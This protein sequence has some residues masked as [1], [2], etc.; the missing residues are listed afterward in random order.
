MININKKKY[1]TFVTIFLFSLIFYAS[2]DILSFIYFDYLYEVNYDAHFLGHKLFNRIVLKTD[3]EIYYVQKF[4]S[5]I[6]KL[7]FIFISFFAYYFFIYKQKLLVNKHSKFI[8]TFFIGVVFLN[9]FDIIIFKNYDSFSN[10]IYVLILVVFYFSINQTLLNS[11]IFTILKNSLIKS[12]Y[13]YFYFFLIL[14]VIIILIYFLKSQG[15]T[16]NLIENGN[17]TLIISDLFYSLER[18]TNNFFSV[19]I[20]P[21][22]LLIFVLFFFIISEVDKKK[23]FAKIFFVALFIFFILKS[24]LFI[25]FS[26]II[27]I[28]KFYERKI[29]INYIINILFF[30]FLFS[31]LFFFPLFFNYIFNFFGYEDFLKS[32]NYYTELLF[33]IDCVS[34]GLNCNF[35]IQ[36]LINFFDI[37][38]LYSIY[39][40]FI[41]RIT[42]NYEFLNYF[43]DNPFVFLTNIDNFNDY[44]TDLNVGKKKNS[45]M[46]TTHNSFNYLTLK[47]SIFVTLIFIFSLYILSLKL[48]KNKCYL[49]LLFL[50]M[51]IGIMLYDDHL[52]MNNLVGSISMWVSLGLININSYEKKFQ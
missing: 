15:V 10:L 2:T 18:F 17:Y 14:T 3:Q 20:N 43:Y 28:F 37:S 48:L 51:L 49:N 40:S 22:S 31:F 6:H 26:T 29:K 39:I 42:M 47:Y 25:I 16:S 46:I 45:I 4:I 9:I 7:L 23:D 41:N 13:L 35:F 8:F 30:F 32:T 52:I 44:I 11:Y 34:K 27:F 5:N 21:L 19:Y 12:Y 24:N 38:F 36:Q 1:E 33:H 50:Y